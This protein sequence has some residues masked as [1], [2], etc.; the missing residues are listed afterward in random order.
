[1]NVKYTGSPL[2]QFVRDMA[3]ATSRQHVLGDY[4]AARMTGQK[5]PV[6][7]RHPTDRAILEKMP[8]IERDKS[9]DAYAQIDE[10]L[11]MIVQG[12][13]YPEALHVLKETWRLGF[14]MR[15]RVAADERSYRDD[16]TWG[17]VRRGRENE[18]GNSVPAG[19]FVLVDLITIRWLAPRQEP[20]VGEADTVAVTGVLKHGILE[21]TIP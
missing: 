4:E 13:D 7:W 21:E 20:L 8:L 12:K 3:V 14:D 5:T 16:I 10:T 9:I 1:M 2:E 15:T 11:E 19:A 17:R 18:F 6:I